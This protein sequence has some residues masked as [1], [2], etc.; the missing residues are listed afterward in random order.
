MTG[1]DRMDDVNVDSFKAKLRSLQ[2]TDVR[3]KTIKDRET[4]RITGEQHYH[5]NGSVGATVMP[6]VTV[7]G[8]KQIK[9]MVHVRME[10]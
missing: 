3:S 5:R 9:E 1:D 2:F 6:E 10:A 7:V 8:A 4:G